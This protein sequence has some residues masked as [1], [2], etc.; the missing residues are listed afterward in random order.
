MGLY[1]NESPR[2]SRNNKGGN[3]VISSNRTEVCFLYKAITVTKR[4]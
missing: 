2:G 4:W 3:K 1:F